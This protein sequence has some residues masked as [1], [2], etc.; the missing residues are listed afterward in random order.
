VS[1]SSTPCKFLLVKLS[2][3]GD[4][5]HNLPI[6]SDIR[7]YYP[8][9]QI[10]WVV[11]E[12]YVD[13]LKPLQ[14]TS[15]FKGIDRI[16]PIALRRWK[17]NIFSFHNW[18]E[19]F[20]FIR[21]LKAEKYDEI[22]DSQGL[23]KSAL[24][25]RLAGKTISGKVTGLA[26]ATE[27]SGYEPLARTFY[28]ESVQVPMQCHAIDRSRYLI[29]SAIRIPLISRTSPIVFYPSQFIEYLTRPLDQS[30]E[31]KLGDLKKPYVLCFHATAREAKKWSHE[32]WITVGKYLIKRGLV[33][34]YP[35]GNL[36]EKKVS[37]EISAGVE[38]SIVP[39]TNSIHD[40]F[41]IISQASLTIGVD[42]GLTH[43]SAVLNRPTIEIYCDSPIWKTEGYWSEKI[44][45]LGNLGKPPSV[46]MVI[47]A[48]DQLI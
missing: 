44:L 43:L 2:S 29:S 12:A 39:S 32:S 8:Q 46:Q 15:N 35:W 31:L 40:Y 6:V 1:Q 7:S 42:T 26:N 21:T 4:V 3:L 47:E 34:I 14:T 10:D 5:L 23:I 33:P 28:D 45:N 22:I 36:A 48:I 37:Q 27:Y 16:I 25:A 24:V 19:L 9:A 38:G 11:E 13:L 17:R 20:Q 18:Q 41:Q 30:T